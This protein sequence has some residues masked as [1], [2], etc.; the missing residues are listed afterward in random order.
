MARPFIDFILAA[1]I[2]A[3]HLGVSMLYARIDVMSSMALESRVALYAAGAGVM[4][5]IAGF[6]G[7]AIALYGSSSGGLVEAIRRKHGKTIRKNWISISVWLLISAT[8]FLLCIILDQDKEANY[9]RWIFG[10]VMVLAVL[11]FL[12]L[13][14]IFNLILLAGDRQIED[15]PLSSAPKPLD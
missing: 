6:A 9:T 15:F 14:S 12:R 3:S 2:A 11:K 4:A 13:V 5:L 8:I 1:S 10:A 7:M